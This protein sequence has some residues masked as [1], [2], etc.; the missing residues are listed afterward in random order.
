MTFKLASIFCALIK[1]MMQLKIESELHLNFRNGNGVQN[2][3]IES[4]QK[5]K[6]SSKVVKIVD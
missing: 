3:N 4:K 1:F 5:T 6:K 2:Q